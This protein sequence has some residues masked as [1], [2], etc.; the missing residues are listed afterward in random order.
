M[1]NVE[2]EAFLTYLAVEGQVSVSTQNPALSA[3]LVLYREV[4]KLD[5]VSIDAVCVK[6][7]HPPAIS[8][9]LDAMPWPPD[10]MLW[11]PDA[12]RLRCHAMSWP[13]DAMLWPPD[14]IRL[15]CHA[16]PWPLD[17]MPL[18]PAAMLM[19]PDAMRL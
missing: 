9:Q 6:R 12:I 11:P 8:M 19:R 2:I 15:R 16:M 14:A 13:L 17:A 4:L 18:H 3:L 1:G 7:S 10:A 5:M